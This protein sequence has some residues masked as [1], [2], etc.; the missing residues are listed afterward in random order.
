MMNQKKKVI[1]AGHICLDITPV[2]LSKKGGKLEELLVPGKLIHMEQANIHTGGAV[3]NTGL[4]M[5]YY[6]SDVK[7]MGKIGKDAFGDIVLSL[8]EKSGVEKDMIIS[9]D[10]MTSYSIVIAPPGVDRIFLHSPGANDSFLSKDIPENAL[11]EVALFHFGYPPLMRSMYE[12]EGGE[13]LEL[14]KRIKARHIATSLDMAAIDAQSDAGKV[15]W[16]KL[17]EKVL[18]YVDFFMPS[19]EELGF[20]LDRSK[21]DD[22]LERAKGEDITSVLSIEEDLKPMVEQLM[23]MGAKVVLIKCGARGMYYRSASKEM[24]MTIGSTLEL[25]YDTWSE[26]EGFEKSYVPECVLSGTGAGDASIAAFLSAVLKGYSFKKSVRLAAASGACCVE[27]YDALS[28]LKSF[29]EMEL[30]IK[31]GWE[32]Q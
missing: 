30:K 4:G 8:L 7:L 5:K 22:W 3:A 29:E 15:D 20:M 19:I 10:V 24:M 21:M 17:L 11:D 13:L 23:L 14:L 32:K 18:P 12:N 31:S 16:M 26:K 1:V 25:D 27:A 2:F 28:G 9:E 6:G